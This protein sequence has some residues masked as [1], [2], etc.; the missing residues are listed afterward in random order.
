M[1]DRYKTAQ[2]LSGFIYTD[3]NQS[4]PLPDGTRVTG[5][6]QEPEVCKNVSVYGPVGG[7]GSPVA[8]GQKYRLKKPN[9]RV[10]V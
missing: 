9:A 7:Q 4:Y 1:V 10:Y 8:A 3:N 5:R 2:F 6:C